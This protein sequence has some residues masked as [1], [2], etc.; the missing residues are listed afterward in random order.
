MPSGGCICAPSLV[1]NVGF[2]IDCCAVVALQWLV[3]VCPPVEE[4][5]L[6]PQFFP[7]PS[8]VTLPHC[9]PAPSEMAQ[10]WPPLEGMHLLVGP[11][12]LGYLGLAMPAVAVL[13]CPAVHCGLDLWL[14]DWVLLLMAEQ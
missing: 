8:E 2:L 14:E 13:Q 1:Q 12:F 7:A 6:R 9:F 3:V 4:V 10:H 5:I 11:V